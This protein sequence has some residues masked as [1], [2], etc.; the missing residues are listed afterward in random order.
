MR[1][2]VISI[3]SMFFVFTLTQCALQQQQ[4]KITPNTVDAPQCPVYGYNQRIKIVVEDD[5][6]NTELGS[7]GLYTKGIISVED[8]I[9]VEVKK[10]LSDR[11]TKCGYVVVDQASNMTTIKT[12]I[13]SLDYRMTMGIVVGKIDINA[14][15]KVFVMKDGYREKFSKMIRSTYRETAGFVK[16]SKK[17]TKMINLVVNDLIKK[18]TMDPELHEAIRR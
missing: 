17:N 15:A 4:V 16:T 14:A 5:R 7:R 3:I 18:I 6:D 9:V 8:D 2:T 13:R 11:F 12:E 1:K 10:A